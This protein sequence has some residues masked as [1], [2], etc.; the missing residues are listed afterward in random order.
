MIKRKSNWF[1]GYYQEWV[2]PS[3]T[4]DTVFALV[5]FQVFGTFL[6]E[7]YLGVLD[8]AMGLPAADFE[9]KTDDGPH[10]FD[11]WCVYCWTW[12]LVCSLLPTIFH[13]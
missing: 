9:A 8:R 7:P 3:V 1:L 12:I 10:V 6:L 11:R 13:K 2:E 5:S 4:Q